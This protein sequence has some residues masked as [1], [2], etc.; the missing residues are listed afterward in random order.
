LPAGGSSGIGE[1]LAIEAAVQGCHVTIIARNH[2]NLEKSKAAIEAAIANVGFT[3]SDRPSV[4]IATC[5][6]TYGGDTERVISTI[7]TRKQINIL[8]T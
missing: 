1:A 3:D 7:H 6:V 5:D 4:D 2:A 8:V